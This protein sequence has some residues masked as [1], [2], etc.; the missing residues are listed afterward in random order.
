MPCIAN[1]KK[2][3]RSIRL[4]LINGIAINCCGF[5]LPLY[6]TLVL[7]ICK[8]V[9]IQHLILL[10]SLAIAIAVVHTYATEKMI[11]VNVVRYTLSFVLLSIAITYSEDIYYILPF[12]TIMGIVLGSDI[13]PSIFMYRSLESE[14]KV[15]VIGG[16][17]ALDSI[18]ISLIISLSILSIF[19][20]LQ[21]FGIHF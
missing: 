9:E 13:L 16:Y 15:L 10:L 3:C 19:R 20:I 1:P 14:S 21:L 5:L 12:S 4:P 17:M 2:V 8:T 11:L 6:S 18:P 7:M